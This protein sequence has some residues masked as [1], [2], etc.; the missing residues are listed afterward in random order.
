MRNKRTIKLMFIVILMSVMGILIQS[1][2]L[3]D[4]PGKYGDFIFYSDGAIVAITGY[5]GYGGAVTIPSQIPVKIPQLDG[6]EETEML[7]VQALGYFGSELGPFY[8]CTILKSIM[9]PSSVTYISMDTFNGCTNLTNIVLPGN[10]TWLGQDAFRDCIR[11]KSVTLSNNIPEIFDGTFYDCSD[12]ASITIPNSVKKIG[13]SVF[14]KC[15]SLKSITLPDSVTSIGNNAFEGCT[16]LASIII[17]SGVTDIKDSTFYRCTGLEKVTIPS[18]VKYIGYSA[19][20]G[21]ADLDNVALPN[22]VTDIKS[23]AFY[24]CA[25]LNN[26]TIPRGVTGIGASAFGECSSLSIVTIPKSV[27]SIGDFAFS[28]CASLNSITVD[29][30]NPSFSSQNGILFNNAKTSLICFPAA[31]KGTYIVPSTTTEIKPQAFEYCA[32]LTEVTFPNNVTSVKSRA[33]LGCTGLTKAIFQGT[34]PTFGNGVFS[35]TASSFKVYYHV[36]KS[37]S[38]AAYSNYPKQAYC[39][40]YI[41]PQNGNGWSEAM[42][43]V[44][45]GYIAAP[46]APTRAGYVFG[47]WYKEA[48]CIHPW[49]FSTDVI[50]NDIS[51]FADWKLVA[52]ESVKAASA[53]YNSIKISWNAVNGANGYEVWRASSG[54]GTYSQVATTASTSYGNTNLATGTQYYYKVRAYTISGSKKY[55]VWSAI[56]SAASV[57]DPPTALSTVVASHTS[58]KLTWGVV[59]GA[60]A[61]E[62]L[63]CATSSPGTYALIATTSMPNYMNGGLT[64]GKTYWYKVR[65]YRLVNN[66]KIYSSYSTVVQARP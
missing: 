3:A 37:A 24:G 39:I 44:N 30:A 6:T 5:T 11:L 9:I 29:V 25:N 16:S 38:W 19:F 40:A 12:L 20:E 32:G 22:S 21:C 48:S 45:F 7:P 55:G 61:Y 27:A 47:G 57:L 8:G 2:A 23:F 49:N 42:M 31:K 46:A 18:S 35:N 50:T 28:G 62:V 59:A 36:S 65:A 66:I 51:L 41:N 54:T 26:M 17:P 60:T 15:T 56:V 13:Y 1:V 52:P 58:I 63:R 53:S 64:A 43:D 14:A 34:K 10:V 4:N 33:F